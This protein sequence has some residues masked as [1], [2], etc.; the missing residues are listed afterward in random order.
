MNMLICIDISYIAHTYHLDAFSFHHG[1]TVYNT[2][3]LNVIGL[4]FKHF[5]YCIVEC[6]EY[7]LLF[8]T[9]GLNLKQ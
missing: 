3:R 6:L 9:D 2:K 7:R 8:L 5:N 4:L 1:L